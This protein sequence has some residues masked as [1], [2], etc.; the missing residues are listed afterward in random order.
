MPQILKYVLINE[1]ITAKF[2]EI[3][4]FANNHFFLLITGKTNKI[5][6]F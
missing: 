1:Y 2:Y 3:V 6:N 5:F 4:N